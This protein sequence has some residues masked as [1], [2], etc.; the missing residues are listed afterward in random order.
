[1]MRR[2]VHA[3]FG[4]LLLASLGGCVA[5]GPSPDALAE[6]TVALEDPEQGG[7]ARLSEL[8]LR[9]PNHL[10]LLDLA[11][12]HSDARG[13]QA[14]RLRYARA[15]FGAALGAGLARTTSK[16]GSRRSLLP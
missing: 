8:L 6:L 4:L 11:L 16:P 10:P 15:A 13:D 5:S 3:A 12:A 9:Y 7:E 2:H 14:G 1:M